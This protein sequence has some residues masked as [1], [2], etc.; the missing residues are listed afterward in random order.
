MRY[1]GRKGLRQRELE[2]GFPSHRPRQCDQCKKR[3]TQE[4]NDVDLGCCSTECENLFYRR[5]EDGT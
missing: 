2:M 1:Q 4:N 5:Y 3:Y